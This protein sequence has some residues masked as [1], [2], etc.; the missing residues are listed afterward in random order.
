MTP[1]QIPNEDYHVRAS[2]ASDPV[3][4]NV[5]LH[6][7]TKSC[8]S[9]D[10][11]TQEART[12]Q[13]VV[14]KIKAGFTHIGEYVR[15]YEQVMVQTQLA[16]ATGNHHLLVGPTGL[17][18]SYYA[19]AVLNLFA[20]DVKRYEN[21][22]TL[23]TTED[24]LYGF[25][26][27]DRIK[28]GTGRR[29]VESGIVAAEVAFLDE[30]FDGR[31]ELLRSLLW[32]LS[33]RRYKNGDQVVQSPLRTVIACGNYV[34]KNEKT[35]AFLDRF[36]FQSE[37]SPNLS[38]LERQAILRNRGALCDVPSIS[39]EQ[40]ISSTELSAIN[41]HVDEM[42]LPHDVA[43]Y[44]DAII[45]EYNSRTSESSV[46]VSGRTFRQMGR[47]IKAHALF[48]GQSAA[49]LDDLSCL[50]L[51]VPVHLSEADREVFRRSWS[52]VMRSASGAEANVVSTLG[53]L[54]ELAR[55]IER[56]EGLCELTLPQQLLTF[57]GI[58]SVQKCSYQG[59]LTAL[60]KL[61]PSLPYF[62]QYRDD[63]RAT[64]Q[65]AI[66]QSK[67]AEGQGTDVAQGRY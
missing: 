3:D 50:A 63:L 7:P 30:I 51:L 52:D 59:V 64:V 60:D 34:R 66:K 19:R 31:D 20:S 39:E 44:L 67:S 46:D 17:G 10:A 35:A 18:K 29:N 33:D 28:D 42:C 13:D 23:E 24:Q 37:I 27:F 25:I 6:S 45:T 21:Q 22:V 36:V 65:E 32:T 62:R 4:L 48:R 11:R 55:L 38:T 1:L 8:A 14:D 12:V 43:M 5:S 47:I 40:K 61:Q 26:P 41:R 9:R 2:V 58:T 16:L 49:T 53:S 54:T 57:L 56:G 15:G